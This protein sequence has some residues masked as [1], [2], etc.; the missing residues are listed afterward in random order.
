MKRDFKKE[1]A[2]YQARAGV[3][4][5]V[6]VPQLRYLMV[7]G[8]GDPN[9]QEYADAV[10]AIFAT[11]YKLKFLSKRELERD[12]VVMPLEA[13]WW[14]DDMSAFTTDRDKSRCS[15]T[16]LNLVPDWIGDDQFQ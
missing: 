1:I 16:A 4:A 14:S 10:A 12:Y 3:F 8:H 2:S 13:L 6:E 7:D 11:A 15:W 5:E 9:G